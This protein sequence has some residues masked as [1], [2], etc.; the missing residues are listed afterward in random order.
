MALECRNMH[1]ENQVLTG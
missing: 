1:R